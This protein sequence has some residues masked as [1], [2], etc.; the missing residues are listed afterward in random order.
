[1]SFNERSFPARTTP[2]TRPVPSK[3]DTGDDLI[4]QTFKEDNETFIITECSR[5]DGLDCLDYI[6]SRTK[7]EFFSTVPEVRKWVKQ[8]SMLQMANNIQPSRKGYM[9]T[10][11]ETMSQHI[12]PR[13][14]HTKLSSSTIKP[15]KNYKDAQGREIQWFEAFRKEK[16]GLLKFNTWKRLDQSKLTPLMRQ[17]AL[18]A[19][20]IY[21]VK[22]D[23][24]AKVR[25]VVNG[26]RQHEST[27]TDTTSPVASQLQLRTLLAITALRKYYMIQMDLTNAYLHADIVDDVYIVIPPGFPGAGEIGRLDKQHMGHDKGPD[28]STTTQ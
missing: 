17:H 23:A 1:M 13:P 25:V 9:N 20:F 7:E 27:F 2:I 19:H 10:L 5:H 6:S 12:N 21:N 3:N 8:T 11:A 18:R 22:R 24:N 14:Y 26:K 15:P 28:D 4:G 16:D